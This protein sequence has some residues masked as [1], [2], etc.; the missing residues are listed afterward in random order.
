MILGV[1]LC[2]YE[3]VDVLS[4]ASLAGARRGS[5]R[6]AGEAEVAALARFHYLKWCSQLPPSGAADLR[7]V[8]A[9][10]LLLGRSLCETT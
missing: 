3:L 4:V 7:L 1:V 5:L 9:S 8:F 2:L 10:V 6:P